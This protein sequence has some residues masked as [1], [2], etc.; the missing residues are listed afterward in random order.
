MRTHARLGFAA[1]I[2][3]VMVVTLL[4]PALTASAALGDLTLVSTS[5]DGTKGDSRSAFPSI[6]PLAPGAPWVA[7]DSQ[8]ANLDPADAD[9]ASDIY[10]KNLAT[11]DV[12]LVSTS[13]DGVKGNVSSSNP[14]I[15]ADGRYVAFESTATNLDPADTD[16]I[17]DIYLKDLATGELTLVSI[18]TLSGEKGNGDSQA[19][20]ILDD[21]GVKVAFLSSATNLDPEDTD[22]LNDV[23]VK[24]LATFELILASTSDAGVKG[25]GASD[26]AMSALSTQ[27]LRVAFSSA[28]SNLDP[29]D[30]D[31]TF[32]VFV[33]NLESGDLM[34]VSTSMTGEKGN[35]VSVADSISGDLV[36]FSSGATNLHPNDGDV[37]ADVYVKDL[38]SGFVW[39]ASTADDGT[40]GNESSGLSSISGSAVAFIS[41]AT[42]FDPDDTDITF[43]VYVKDLGT[44][45]LSLASTSSAGIKA[46][47]SSNAPVMGAGLVAFDSVATNLDPA[48]TDTFPDVYVKVPGAQNTA[49]VAG[50]DTYSTDE[51]VDLSVPGPGVLGNDTDADGDQITASLVSGP[52]HG[53]AAL[54]IDGS[55]QYTPAAG[56]DGTD[57][58]TYVAN[59]GAGDSNVATVTITV[60]PAPACT[61]I[62]LS[63]DDVSV[64]EGNK[65]STKAVFT[66]SLSAP[67]Q[68]PVTVVVEAV[69]GTAIQG[70]DYAPFSPRTVTFKGRRTT[71]TVSVQVK[72][73]RL[74]EP[75]E[76]FFVQ[77]SAPVNAGIS[78]GQ[79]LGTILNDD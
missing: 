52:A 74:F 14:A 20:S 67:S 43:D 75:N 69:D 25:N 62:C 47:G 26:L 4:G 6:A 51:N 18:S 38:A 50:D 71:A 78:D 60:N 58:F 12:T 15:S 17:S 22:T 35:Q 2:V 7:F 72:G 59:D 5:D 40:K 33:K 37:H 30:P 77:L 42:N 66:I 9:H 23:Y 48:D 32:D 53:M 46:N 61:G 10:V 65:G 16:G 41:S 73:D 36:A 24:D 64:G 63:V 21:Q 13:T 79:G 1:S 55:F 68:S 27:P 3:V 49:P 44:L 34:L 70:V 29:N 11:G 45:D 57:M 8:A 31:S 76:T 56:F 54:G 28:A 19:P 39:L